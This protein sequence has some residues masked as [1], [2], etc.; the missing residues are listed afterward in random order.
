MHK[1]R[2]I[3]IIVLISAMVSGCWGVREIEHLI[4]VNSIGVD[5]VKGKYVFYT[6]IISFGNIAK[7]EAGAQRLP[8]AISIGKAEGETIDQAI[9]NLYSTTQQRLAWSHVKAIVFSEAALKQDGVNQMLDVIDRYY[10][11]R[12]TIWTFATNEPIKEVFNAQPILNI[13]V[14]YSQLNDPQDIYRQSSVVAP[15]YLYKFIWKWK[16]NGQ[17]VQLPLLNINKEQWT[18]NKK[19]HPKLIMDGVCFLQNKK[20]KQCLRRSDVMGLRWLD[21][22]TSRAGLMVRHK[23]RIVATLTLENIK[24]AIIPKVDNGK[25]TYQIKVKAQANM[26][27]LVKAIPEEKISE[28]AEENI[29]E[30]IRHTYSLGLKTQTDVLQLSDALYRKYPKEWHRLT[31]EGELPLDKGMISTID[32]KVEMFSG[33]MSKIR[34]H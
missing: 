17:T 27:Q 16:E 28:F 29:S 19:R 8:Q 1:L 32:V 11:F 30:E 21:K 7:Q 4:Y 13:S 20:L 22:D 31:K 18:E 10:E 26:P 6:Q 34:E 25:V 5:Y 2:C 23:G 14:L 9:F 33:S 3:L 15:L 24:P 12:Y